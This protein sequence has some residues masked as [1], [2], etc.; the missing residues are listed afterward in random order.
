MAK[1]HQ[2]PRAFIRLVH[3]HMQ[4]VAA[5]EY[6]EAERAFVAVLTGSGIFGPVED[7]RLKLTDDMMQRIVFHPDGTIQLAM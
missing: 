7:F 3:E 5:L 1:A 4:V 2:P 6:S